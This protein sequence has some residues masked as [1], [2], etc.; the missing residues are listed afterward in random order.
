SGGIA[1][2]TVA[3]PE[4]VPFRPQRLRFDQ[5]TEF[6]FPQ[7]N[8]ARLGRVELSQ[9]ALVTVSS[10]D[11]SDG[12]QNA[13]EIFVRAGMLTLTGQ[14]RISANEVGFADAGRVT[15]TAGDVSLTDNARIVATSTGN[16]NGGNI[17][18]RAGT[19]TLTGRTFISSG[20]SL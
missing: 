4:E 3:L 1:L 12:R 8:A 20:Q 10:S 7:G 9:D 15:V 18:V 16:G 14:A 5:V 11:G 6:P 2:V 17:S 19:L 13:G